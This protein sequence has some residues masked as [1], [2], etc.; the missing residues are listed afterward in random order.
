MKSQE[1]M[2]KKAKTRP[3]IT[4]PKIQ[5]INTDAQQRASRKTR[6]IVQTII[7][8]ILVVPFI[9]AF[10]EPQRYQFLFFNAGLLIIG[11][12]LLSGGLLYR[13]IFADAIGIVTSRSRRFYIILGL[14]FIV[15][16]IVVT[17]LNLK[18]LS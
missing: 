10:S 7:L 18:N 15:V 16:A 12:L 5:E 4:K 14:A 17:L 3:K 1:H 13:T 9:L 8:I 2:P 11:L 6:T